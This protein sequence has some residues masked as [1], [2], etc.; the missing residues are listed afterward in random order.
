MDCFSTL[1]Y[2][3]KAVKRVQGKINLCFSLGYINKVFMEELAFELDFEEWKGAEQLLI[4]HLERAT[5]PFYV[6]VSDHIYEMEKCVCVCELV[7]F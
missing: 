2:S 4:C 6:T 5:H 1:V 3:I 7:N